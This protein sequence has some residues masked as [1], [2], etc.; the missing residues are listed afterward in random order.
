LPPLGI[1]LR[2]TRM[3]RVSRQQDVTVI[4]LGASYESLDKCVLEDFGGVL[5][6]EAS[7]AE[8]PRMVL[9]LSGTSYVGSAFIELV[10]RAWKRLRV[11]G[12]TMVLCG[13]GP[14]CAEVLRVTRLDQLWKA[15]PT[16]DQA[17]AALG[18]APG[19]TATS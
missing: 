12:G 9:D 6:T 17:V 13:L 16:R 19:Q 2:L 7:R 10:V 8:P 1:P 18:V 4:E 5:L 15:F 14:L 11:R 3:I